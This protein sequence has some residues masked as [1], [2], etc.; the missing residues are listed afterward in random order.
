MVCTSSNLKFGMYGGRGDD[1]VSR[2]VNEGEETRRDE[3][4]LKC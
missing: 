3:D 1:E 4:G 2:A